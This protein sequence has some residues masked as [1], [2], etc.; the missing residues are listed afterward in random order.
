MTNMY[1]Y[2]PTKIFSET[3]CVYNHR[4]ELASLGTKAFIIT[5]ASS[6]K[7]NGSLD[8]VISALH[9]ESIPYCIYHEIEENPS[10]ET[11]KKASLIG[12][13][14]QVDFVIG[15][16]G[17]SPLDAAKA[18]ALMIYNKNETTDI[19]YQTKPLNALPVAAVPTTAGTGSEATPYAILTLHNERTKR[20]ISHRVF[21]QIAF[22]DYSY[23]KT[24]PRTILINT[25]IDALSHLIESYINTNATTYSKMFCEYGLRLWGSVKQAL[26]DYSCTDNDFKALMQASTIAGIAISHTGTSL[27]HGMSYSLT[28]EKSIPHGKATG[29]FLASY[30]NKVPD[31]QTKQIIINLLG[32]RTIDYL[33]KYIHSLLGD[34]T[35][36]EEE[37][38]TYCSNM[39][40][41]KSKLANCPYEVTSEILET[42]F[43]DSLIIE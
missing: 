29:I 27:P 3:N 6:S 18:I 23:L 41:N 9:G 13:K 40:Q 5:G 31:N 26:L 43:R 15:I 22:V 37:L 7:E 21:P 19:L 38:Q 14:E 20:S 8:D 25:A 34:V 36:R 10:V 39:L 16:G 24:I 4:K 2:M 12:I 33:Y 11:I 32:F 42:I 1:F 30:I 35:I 17:G 28:Y